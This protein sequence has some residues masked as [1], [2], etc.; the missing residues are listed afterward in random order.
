MGARRLH[1]QL[2]RGNGRLRSRFRVFD[3]FV[4]SAAVAAAEAGI[5]PIFMSM[6]PEL[7]HGQKR[8][9]ATMVYYMACR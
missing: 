5:A 2:G 7:F 3:L 8:I 9:T 6:L 1:F 4:A